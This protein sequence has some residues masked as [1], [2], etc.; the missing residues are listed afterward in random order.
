MKGGC[1]TG[2]YPGACT[3]AGC[4]GYDC[5]GGPLSAFTATIVVLSIRSGGML[6]GSCVTDMFISFDGSVYSES[7][8]SKEIA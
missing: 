8:Y 4:E 5:V 2:A 1:D 3:G 7:K 6:E